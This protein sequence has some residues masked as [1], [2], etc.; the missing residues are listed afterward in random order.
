MADKVIGFGKGT[1]TDRNGNSVKWAKLYCTAPM[2]DK[3]EG[4]SW[5]SG[6]R[7]YSIPVDYAAADKLFSEIIVGE[8]Y[9]VDF[10]QYGKAKRVSGSMLF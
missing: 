5:Y 4:E 3:R 10:N 2:D 6:Q 8:E 1:F 9:D 7:A